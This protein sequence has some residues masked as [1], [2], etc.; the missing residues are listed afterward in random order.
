MST[1]L[2]LNDNNFNDEV[3]KSETVVLVDFWAEWCGPCKMIAPAVENISN[4]FE[5]KLKV[6]KLD[7]DSNPVTSSTFGIRSIPTLLIFK[8]GS[9]VEQIVGAV[10]ESIISAKV[11][12]HI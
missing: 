2:E 1:L 11:E 3:I 9:P 5:G 12:N 4:N 6:G 7:V 10:S 8:N